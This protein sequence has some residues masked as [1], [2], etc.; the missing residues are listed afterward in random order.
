MIEENLIEPKSNDSWNLS[1]MN[2]I[3]TIPLYEKCMVI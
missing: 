2:N 1:Q 3:S